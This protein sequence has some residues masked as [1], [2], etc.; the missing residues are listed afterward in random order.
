M[1]GSKDAIWPAVLATEQ[2]KLFTSSPSAKATIVPE[3]SHFVNVTQAE[4]VNT[5]LL[6][7]VE[8]YS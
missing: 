7:F 8:Q 5:A 6:D 3:G 1:Q 2:I 4:G